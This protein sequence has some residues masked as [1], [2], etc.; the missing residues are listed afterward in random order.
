MLPD[1]ATV[2]TVV[3]ASGWLIVVVYLCCLVDGFFPPVP[4]ET[5]VLAALTLATA[6]E[7]SPA[8]V[9][10]ILAAASLGAASGDTIAHLIGRRLGTAGGAWLR[11]PRVRAAFDWARAQVTARPASLILGARY[12]P[13][14]RV[15]VNVAT[16]A[17]GMTLR[18]FVPLSLLAGALWTLMC[19]GLATLVSAWLGHSPV[20]AT[21]VAVAVS[22]VLGVSVD[23]ISRLVRRRRAAESPLTPRRI[24]S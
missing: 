4:S 1:I 7:A 8:L 17:S 11:R 15:A 20:L 13:V 21:L 6:S 24:P 22:I 3:G 5:V 12:I 14:G 19:W 23:A 10:G 16:G 2:L 9:A 18:R